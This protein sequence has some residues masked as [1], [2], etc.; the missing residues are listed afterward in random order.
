VGE[1][2]ALPP[3]SG[4]TTLRGPGGDTV[5]IEPGAKTLPPLD[6]PGVY[7]LLGG[8][9]TLRFAV[10]LDPNESRTT[11]LGPDEL[12]QLGVPVARTGAAPAP[13]PAETKTLLQAI[14]TENRQKLWRWFILAT[15]AV[16]L[17]ESAIA[18]WTARRAAL[19]SKEMTS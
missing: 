12:E 15:L 17:A 3:E 18:G 4:V 1:P 9:R 13:V 14:E 2:I 7:E 16:L 19:Q 10:N 11:P 6:R 8:A 5:A